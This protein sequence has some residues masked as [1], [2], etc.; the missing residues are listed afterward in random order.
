MIKYQISSYTTDS[1]F[2][3][4]ALDLALYDLYQL[5]NTSFFVFLIKG[6]ALTYDIGRHPLLHIVNS[7]INE[8]QNAA[9]KKQK[10]T[11]IT[12]FVYEAWKVQTSLYVISVAS[13]PNEKGTM[14]QKSHRSSTC[15]WFIRCLKVHK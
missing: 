10:T 8:Q 3:E 11:E 14:E 1:S 12:A 15:F 9:K 2:S 6:C 13:K 4:N 7:Q 5:Y